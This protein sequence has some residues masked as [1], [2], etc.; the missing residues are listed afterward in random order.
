VIPDARLLEFE[1]GGHLLL[2]RGGEM[3][4]QVAAFMRA[5]ASSAAPSPNDMTA[6]SR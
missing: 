5:G 2:G 6:G 4:P 1:S 3:W